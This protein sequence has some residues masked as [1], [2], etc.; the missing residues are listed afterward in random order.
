MIF[1]HCVV[2]IGEMAS[3]PPRGPAGLL[4]MRDGLG[5]L[6]QTKTE[7]TE[8][9]M[10][11]ALARPGNRMQRGLEPLIYELVP[12][13]HKVPFYFTRQNRLRH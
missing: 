9:R 3:A 4:F 5:L 10:L 12:L 6:T 2:N 7:G 13:G 8:R 1:N 11:A